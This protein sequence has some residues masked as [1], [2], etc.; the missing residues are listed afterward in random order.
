MNNSALLLLTTAFMLG[1]RHGF[2]LDHLATID[3][4]TRALN[5]QRLLSKL[6][7]I[8]FSFGHGLV[9]ITISLFI[10]SGIQMT[11]IPDW[12]H[13]FGDG[14]SIVFL[15]LFGALN[16]CNVFRN[17]GQA[18]LPTSLKSWLSKKIAPHRINPIFIILVGVLFAFSFDT[19]S[20]VILFSLSASAV[21]GCL[22][23]GLL[24]I[25]FMLGMMSSD[26]LNGLLVS[27]LVQRAEAASFVFSR[28][29]AL[30]I[31][32]FSLVIGLMNCFKIYKG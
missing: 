17:P 26:G 29:T 4:M 31:A 24:G 22:F 2:D 16:L 19:V 27:G 10:G 15:F 25:V 30:M 5:K 12:L 13:G 14:V 6:T 8:L 21:A 18:K 9:V 11:T 23:S 32:S 3:A 28:L 20:Q 7:G 1:L